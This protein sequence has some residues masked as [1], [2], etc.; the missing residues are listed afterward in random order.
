MGNKG[1]SDSE[2]NSSGKKKAK[3]IKGNGNLRASTD[4]RIEKDQDKTEKPALIDVDHLLR[5]SQT[6][7]NYN[8][9][10]PQIT[11]EKIPVP[12]GYLLSNVLT[13]DECEQYIKISEEMGYEP[14]PLRN[15]G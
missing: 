5:Y 7:V 9:N 15:L 2:S 10:P 8:N 6:K 11:V 3:N 13:K 14:A 1:S 12:S 4:W